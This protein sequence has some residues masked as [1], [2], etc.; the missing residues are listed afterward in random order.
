VPTVAEHLA[1]LRARLAATA[2]ALHAVADDL[3]PAQRLW[4][5]APE[6]WG[7]ADC[8]E[9]LLTVNALYVPRVAAALDAAGPPD[10][11][12]DARPWRPTW[13]GRWFVRTAGPGGRPIRTF[14]TFAPPPARPDAPERLL[15]AQAEL[16]ALLDR[17]AGRDLRVP[18]VHSPVTRL[19][20]L[21]AGEALE[22]LV[23][24]QDRHLEQAARVRREPAFPR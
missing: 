3:T 11:A 12:R 9:H 17:A 24:H 18:R 1:A 7:V 5:P 13:F 23:V 20:T 22:M 15:A 21:R 19:L 8:C 16:H 4:R 10:A 2:A 14:R 6:R